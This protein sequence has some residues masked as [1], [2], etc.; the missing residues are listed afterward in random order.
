MMIL[1]DQILEEEEVLLWVC[2]CKWLESPLVE[3]QNTTDFFPQKL[4]KELAGLRIIKLENGTSA[5]SKGP[6]DDPKHD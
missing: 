5:E 4:P 3:E 2:H 1:E 6:K